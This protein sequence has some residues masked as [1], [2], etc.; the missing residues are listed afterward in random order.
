MPPHLIANPQAGG[1]RGNQIFKR[2]CRLLEAA[3]WEFVPHLTG[4][5]GEAEKLALEALAVGSKLVVACG[6]DGTVNEVLNGL[7]G[8]QASLGIIPAGRGNDL[9]RALGIPRRVAEACA[10]LQRGGHR[11]IDTISLGDR[12]FCSVAGLGLGAQVNQLANQ[13]AGHGPGPL[14]Y[15]LP[16]V[17]V[18]KEYNFPKIQLEYD[19]GS[20]E[21]ELSL[22]AVANTPYYG[23][24][25]KIAPAAQP[26][27][28]LLDIYIVEKTS[29]AS[30]LI[31]LPSLFRG[32]HVNK[33]YVKHF[34][35][36]QLRIS[37]P[38]PLPI[39]ADGEFFQ[40][41]PAEFR[42]NPLSLKVIV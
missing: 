2:A 19:D 4:Q 7:R 18:L 33:P 17:R 9:A 31:N 22:L 28:G 10:L 3:G 27:D 14:P 38:Q 39:F 6:G 35:S 29:K 32:G 15:L 36:K 30:L 12:L 26:D 8:S 41:T 23:G 24:G 40:Q 42:V 11:R 16:L 1:G 13:K 25:M 20:Y 5:P 34:R 37:S 21:G